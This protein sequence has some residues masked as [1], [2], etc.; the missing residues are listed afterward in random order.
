MIEAGTA[1]PADHFRI[2]VA[3]GIAPAFFSDAA[4]N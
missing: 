2:C 1:G 3:D 4:P